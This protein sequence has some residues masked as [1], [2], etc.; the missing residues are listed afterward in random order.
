MNGVRTAGS[1]QY[2]LVV[3]ADV[4]DRFYT[5][6]LLQRF[7]YDVFSARTAE[8]AIEFITVSPPTAILADADLNGST[9]FSWLSKDPRFFDIPL[10]LL[11]WWP[12]PAL[13]ARANKGGFAAYLRKPNNVEEFYQ[14]V[15]IAIEKGPRRNLR[16]ATRLMARLEDGQDKSEGFVTVLSEYGMF[17]M[18]LDPRPVN[19]KIPLSFTMKD[20]L[21]K[22]EAV[23]LYTVSFDDGPYKEPGMGLKFVKIS[24]ADRSLIANFM[25]EWIQDGASKQSAQP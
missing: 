18:T 15:Q 25:L 21:I 14:I 8:E 2:I 1:K 6:M 5:C 24:R 23:V 16:I 12:N 13:E 7:G 9:M 10:V 17:F 11:S 19:A 20:S 22:V 3:D 4:N